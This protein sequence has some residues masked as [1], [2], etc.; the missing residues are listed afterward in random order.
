MKWMKKDEEYCTWAFPPDF[1]KGSQGR[2]GSDQV[3][4]LYDCIPG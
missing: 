2:A 3:S 4:G 1:E